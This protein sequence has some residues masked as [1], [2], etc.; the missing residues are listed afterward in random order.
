MSA[1]RRLLL[2]H[3][4]PDDESINNG[5]TMAQYAAAGARVTLV[6]CT[7]GELGEVLEPKYA[8]LAADKGDQ[9]GGYRISEL[10]RAMQ[11]LGVTDHRFLGQAGRWR[12]SGMAGTPGNEDP[13]AFWRCAG[14]PGAFDTAVNELVDVIREVRP[15]VLVTYDEN[16][17]YGHPDHIM[18]HRVAV[19]A[20]ERAAQRGGAGEPWSI[21]KFYYATASRAAL[22]QLID[23]ALAAGD[24]SPFGVDRAEDLPFGDDEDTI[25]TVIDARASAPAKL[26]ALRAYRTQLDDN[27]PFFTMGSYID[28]SVI[29]YE[30]YRLVQGALGADRDADGREV[31]LF[32]GTGV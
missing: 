16:G 5:A 20:T 23:A 13:R 7:L 28:E 31:D 10:A 2:V 21:A 9:L 19:A 29:G 11:L 24:A 30:H 22:Q 17:G 4:H 18:A 25:T 27:A 12:D 6:T 32:A 8:G 1:D 26:A 14:D 15:Q 3:A